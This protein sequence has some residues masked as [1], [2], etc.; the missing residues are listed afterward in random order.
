MFQP[1]LIVGQEETARTC[2]GRVQDTQ[3]ENPIR[4]LIRILSKILS[5]ILVRFLLKILNRK[6]ASE[7][8]QNLIWNLTRNPF[9]I[10]VRRF[11]LKILNRKMASESDKNLIW[12]LTRNPSRILVGFLLKILNRI[13]SDS[14]GFLRCLQFPPTYIINCPMLSI[15]LIMSSLTLSSQFKSCDKYVL[16]TFEKHAWQ[17]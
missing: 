7:S 17:Q 10:L 8:D 14:V 6:M 16:S 3:D 9:R 15:D 4:N 2:Q 13:L 5:R 12:N 11:L 1:V